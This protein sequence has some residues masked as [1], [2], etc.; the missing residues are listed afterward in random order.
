MNKNKI[1]LLFLVALIYD[2]SEGYHLDYCNI[3]SLSGGGSFGAVEV[4]ILESIHNNWNISQYDLIT[5]VSVGGLNAA[6]L[7]Y[8]DD[9]ID[10][11]NNLKEIY[12]N[13]Q[14]KDIYKINYDLNLFNINKISIFNTDPLEKTIEKIL[15]K[16]DDNKVDSVI[17][18]T[19]LNSGAFEMFRLNDYKKSDK[20]SLLLTTSA[21]PFAFPPRSFNGSLYVD[22]GLISNGIINGIESLI[23]CE[24]YNL[25]YISSHNE[26]SK[27]DNIKN[28]FHFTDRVINLLYNDFD[29][30]IVEIRNLVCNSKINNINMNINYC[31]PNSGTLDKYSI[32][33][34][35]KAKELIDI[36]NKNHICEK[37]NL[38]K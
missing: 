1:F 29:N 5:G 23:S 30:Q 18:S 8:Y 6:Y 21:I 31:Y 13:L 25:T 19:N 14:N 16:F 28:I 38:C 34:F 20:I 26:I 15:E 11:I 33:D 17:G 4:G 37:I 9:I 12:E 3:L 22:G 32:L 27:K 10:G 7:S 36:G 24:N 2:I 35:T